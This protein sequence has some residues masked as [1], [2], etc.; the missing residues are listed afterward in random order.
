MRNII[1]VILIWALITRG[2]IRFLGL[3]SQVATKLGAWNNVHSSS[4]SSGGWE[5]KFKGVPSE[6]LG[7]MPFLSSSCFW[8][9]LAFPATALLQSLPLSSHCL[10]FAHLRLP[11]S[12]CVSVLC[13]SLIN[14][15]A[16]GLRAQPDHPGSSHHAI[17]KWITPAK[18]LS[19]FPNTVISTGARALTKTYLLGGG[20]HHSTHN[21]NKKKGTDRSRKKI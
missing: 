13:V 8:R 19:R 17:L 10:L 2:W 14:T 1:D 20:R 12:V 6:V 16:I 18:N 3:L 7:E 15:P 9:L 5:S 4:C 11:L 21:R